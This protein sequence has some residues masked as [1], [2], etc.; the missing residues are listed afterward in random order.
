MRD[1]VSK[2]NL[3]MVGSEYGSTTLLSRSLNS[4]RQAGDAFCEGSEISYESSN[5]HIRNGGMG[6]TSFEEFC[7]VVRFPNSMSRYQQTN[8]PT[9]QTNQ[10]NN[11]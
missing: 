10:R 5:T 2:I 7:D 1:V 9:K 4:G 6:S 11:E 3:G 8:K